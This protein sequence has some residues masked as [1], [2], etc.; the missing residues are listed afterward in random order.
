MFFRTKKHSHYGF[1]HGFHRWFVRPMVHI[2]G[3][4][5]LLTM[6]YFLCLS[7]Q[8]WTSTHTCTF[9][10]RSEASQ[11]ISTS[12][13]YLTP[14]NK[15]Y[16]E[17]VKMCRFSLENWFFLCSLQWL[18]KGATH[19]CTSKKECNKLDLTATQYFWLVDHNDWSR[20]GFTMVPV[21]VSVNPSPVCSWET[22]CWFF[23]LKNENFFQDMSFFFV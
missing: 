23:Y 9:T 14:D 22:F 8:R 16:C 15:I 7:W 13:Q 19:L 21:W 3:V 6:L 5:S 12:A 2:L 1:T 18:V 17:K 20:R 10:F 11:S 4:S